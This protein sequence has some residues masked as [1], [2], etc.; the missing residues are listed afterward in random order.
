[1]KFEVRGT[2]DENENALEVS[3]FKIIQESK[4]RGMIAFLIIIACLVFLA[5]SALYGIAQGDF[6]EL[7]SVASYIQAP[8]Y[9]VTGY[10]F[11]V[12]VG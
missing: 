5:G 10:Y 2:H 8:L 11:G 1:M 9:M 12:K 6:K 3:G 7:E 4:M